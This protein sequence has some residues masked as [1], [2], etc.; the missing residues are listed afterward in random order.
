[1]TRG[2][3]RRSAPSTR[4]RRGGSRCSRRCRPTSRT[5]RRCSRWP[6]RTRTLAGEID[7]QIAA[8]ERRLAALEEQRLFSGRY[9]ARRRARD[10][11]TRARAAP[12]PRT[13]RRWCCG[14]RCAGPSSA[15]STVELLEVSA[16]EEAGIKSATFRVSGENAYGL[17]GAEKRRAPARAAARRSTRRTAARRASRASRSRRSSRTPARSRSTR[18]TCRSTPT[19]RAARAA[20]TSTR[21]TRRFG[22][23]IARPGSSCSARTSAPNRR[24]SR[25]A[26]AML[27]AKLLEREERERRE[28]IAREKGEAQDV[29][30]GSQIRSYVLHP[31]TIV[32][33]HRTGLRD[34]RRAARA[35]RRPRRIRARVPAGTSW[36]I[37]RS[38]P[39]RSSSSSGSALAEDVGTGDVTSEAT[40]P[41]DARARAVITQK[42]DGVIYGL[43]PA[44]VAFTLTDPDAKVR[45]SL[46]EGE[47]H[48]AGGEVSAG[49]GSDAGAPCGGAHRAQLP[50]PPV[51]GRDASRPAASGASTAPAR[52]YW[53]RA[54]RRQACG[55]WRRRR[56]RRAG[57]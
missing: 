10:A 4:A 12:T 56:S 25:R 34:G 13:G 9:D 21:P 28:E 11:S 55:R 47:W 43:V 32:K 30:F 22:S 51:G 48:E 8:V 54:R 40:V 3:P 29:N 52:S 45:R 36:L 14:W 7:E 16:G 44:A 23:R 39:A 33:D 31:Y 27:R 2:P 18:T 5:W 1:M 57:R 50:R 26:M 20:S 19:E 42:Q 49:R 53:T 37:G 38:L 15:A 6:P 17:F 46:D 41:A 24:T 35:R